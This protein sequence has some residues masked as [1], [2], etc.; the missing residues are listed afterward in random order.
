MAQ[1]DLPYLSRETDRH[2]NDRIYV[3]R[4]GKRFRLREP[5]GTPAFAKEYAE[6]VDK[7][8]DPPSKRKAAAAVATHPKD[9]LGW[10]GAEYFKSKDE[11]EFLRLAKDSQRARRNCLEECFRVPLSDTDPDPIGNCPL[12]YLSAQKA[13]RMIEAA[14]GNGARTN[15][16]K[17]LSAL[18]AWGVENRLLPSN[19]V[20]DIKAGR[21]VKGGGYYTWVIPDIEQFLQH[22]NG[23]SLKARKSE[24]GIGAAVVLRHAAPGHG[25]AWQAAHAI[26]RLDKVRPQEDAL[27]APHR[28]SE[29][30]A[31]DPQAD[32]RREPVWLHDLP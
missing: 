16:R 6:A 14:N 2:G 10:L 4:N 7:L 18:C 21:H 15:R 30:P 29:A 25:D 9:T 5:E 3:R 13:K 28:R 11:G 27:Q 8:G 26:R 1:T 23:D 12:K 22:H 19:P 31:P 24:A 20:R 32:Y 17:H